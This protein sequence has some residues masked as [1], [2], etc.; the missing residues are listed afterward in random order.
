M[1][2]AEEKI[3]LARIT[4][5]VIA[6]LY[7]GFTI[8]SELRNPSETMVRNIGIGVA[9]AGIFVA[10]AFMAK[11]SPFNGI[12]SALILYVLLII[13]EIAVSEFSIVRGIALRGIVIAILVRALLVSKEY[14][15]WK[16]ERFNP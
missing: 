3:W 9:I 4:I 2:K 5:F 14:E 1:Q 11:E 13:L 16:K 15:K 10:F 7:I 12:L 8:I 6:G